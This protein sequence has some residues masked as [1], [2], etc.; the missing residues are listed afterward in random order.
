MNNPENPAETEASADLVAERFTTGGPGPEGQPDTVDESASLPSQDEPE[1]A[2]KPTEA[3]LEPAAAPV[4][5]TPAEPEASEP[6]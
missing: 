2:Q 3:P 5:D 4:S 6:A 1:A